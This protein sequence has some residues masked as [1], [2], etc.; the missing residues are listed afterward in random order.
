[1]TLALTH[2]VP[3][4]INA[5]ELTYIERRPIDVALAEQQHLNYRKTLSEL[6]VEVVNLSINK[7]FPDAVFVEDAAVVVDEMAIMTLPGAKSRRGELAAWET[8][9]AKYREITHLQPPATLDGGD[10]LRIG[11]RLFVGRSAR[12]NDEGIRGLGQV[13]HPLGYHVVPVEIH[14][15]LHLKT[16]CTALDDETVLVNPI[17][18]DTRPLAEAG[19]Q[20][21][22]VAHGENWAANVIPVNGRVLLGAGNPYTS[23]KL[24]RLGYAVEPVDIREFE[25]AEGSLSCLSIIFELQP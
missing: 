12:T 14:D 1:M 16:T 7:D 4:D 23:E 18:L 25:K 20:I 2:S 17:W 13:L 8:E 9:L 21:V 6:G 19:F 3:A 22:E 24:V 15:V 11:K 5:C 10:V